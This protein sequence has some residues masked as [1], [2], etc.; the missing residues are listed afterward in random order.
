MSW[1][2][3][4]IVFSHIHSS[5]RPPRIAGPFATVYF[6]H[7][8]IKEHPG[9]APIALHRYRQWVF[10]SEQFPRIDISSAVTMHFQ[11]DPERRSR[12]LASLKRFSLFD[13]LIYGDDKAVAHLDRENRWFCY[14]LGESWPMLVLRDA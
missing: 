8:A 3:M 4:K 2:P 6:D 7:A 9:A 14:D 13:G 10:E 11:A 1:V 12:S 5:Y